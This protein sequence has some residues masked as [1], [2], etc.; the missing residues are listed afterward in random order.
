MKKSNI[1]IILTII[2]ILIIV[3]LIFAYI[4]INSDKEAASIQAS[5]E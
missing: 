3:G 2:V 4:S 5:I 1:I